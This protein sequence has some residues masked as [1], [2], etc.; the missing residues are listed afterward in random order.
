[1]AISMQPTERL[2]PRCVRSRQRVLEAALE[3][4][5]DGGLA[6]LN[7]EAVAARSGVAKT[8][9]YRHFPEHQALHLAAIEFA[10]PLVAMR[11]TDDVVADLT[12]YLTQL[13]EALLRG[14]FG[15]VLPSV[16]DVAERSDRM[17]STARAT[18]AQRRSVMVD[19]LHAAQA[20]GS[21]SADADADLLCAAL[22]G[23]LFYRR[24]FS[25]QPTSH[26]FIAALTRS[27]LGPYSS[28]GSYSNVVFLRS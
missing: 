17:A 2:D 14:R 11:T 12:G 5:C 15:S 28:V 23:P 1:M 9:I 21:L 4:L 13:N 16:V 25:R 27:V 20:T 8:T 22:V 6:T 24:F 3:L 19:R 7:Y 10:A 18:A 26:A